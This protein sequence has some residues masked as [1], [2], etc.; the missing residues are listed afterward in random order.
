MTIFTTI[1]NPGDKVLIPTPA[2][3]SYESIV[4][5]LGGSVINYSLNSKNFSIDIEK[6]EKQIIEEK[7]KAMVLSYP[8]NPTGAVL[9]KKTRDALY[10]IIKEQDIYV[11]DDE[12]YGSIIFQEDYYSICQ[13]P[14]IR[15]KVIFLN[16][17]SKMFSM[18]GL[19]LG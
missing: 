10:K 15:D 1:I 12:I 2:Y 11:I 6:L 4:K 3:P 9:D 7:P 14:E 16:G 8:C 5:I 19:R 17:F 13:Y 18:T